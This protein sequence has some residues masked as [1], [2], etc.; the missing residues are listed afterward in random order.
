MNYITLYNG[1]KMPQLG[2]GVYQVTKDECE[3]CVSD[4]LKQAIGS[5][6]PHRVILTR[7]KWAMPLLKA[8]F[9]EKKSF[10]RLRCGSN[11]TAA[12]QPGLLSEVY[13][14]GMYGREHQCVRLCTER[15]RY[16]CNRCS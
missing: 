15:G 9:P 4:A 5:L 2:Y 16:D 11:T 1:V 8:V 12:K 3:R 6:T 7:K 14:H 13:P 10:L